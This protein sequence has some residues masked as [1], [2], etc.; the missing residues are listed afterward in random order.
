MNRNLIV[1][2]LSALGLICAHAGWAQNLGG[3]LL[4]GL[5][6]SQ[7]DGDL[8]AGYNKAGLVVGGFA[9]YRFNSTFVLQP[10]IIFEQLGSAQKNVGRIVN[11]N[12]FSFPVLVRA[13]VPVSL[14][15][16]QQEVQFFAGPVAGYLL[17]AKDFNNDQ[18]EGLDKWDLR[19]QLGA[20]FQ[21][22]NNSLQVLY[23]YS[24]SSLAGRAS[25]VGFLQAGARG[26][27]HHYISF[28][29]HFH[30]AYPR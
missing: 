5:N 12:Y 26:L 6:V 21:I 8:Y 25:G 18:V 14:G 19:G 4:V 2:L 22:G 28:T 16:G 10:Q 30:L 17:S 24:L 29:L 27:F 23:G 9:T 3:G 7:V 15:S 20:G 1:G 11:M 13:D